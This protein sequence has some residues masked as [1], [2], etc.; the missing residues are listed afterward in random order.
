[1][2]NLEKTLWQVFYFLIIVIVIK[3][4]GN[5]FGIE[6][7]NQSKLFNYVFLGLPIVLLILHSIL[8][9]GFIR[10]I[11]FILLAST[12]GT[13][14]EHIGLKYGTF[15][16]GNY[17][18]KNQLTLFSVPV[19]VIF[20]WAVFI[21]TGYCLTNSFLYWLKKK[22]PNIK[23]KNIILLIII[24]LLDAYFITAIDLFMDPIAVYSGSWKWL[25]GGPYFGVPIGNFIG[26]FVV[27]AIVVSIFRIFEYYFPQKEKKFNK[28]IFIIPV[29]GYGAMAISYFLTAIKFNLSLAVV[30]VVFMLPQII[31]NLLLFKKFRV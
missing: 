10:G 4:I 17:I 12:T 7:E 25:E 3:V 13:F 30:G 22:K 26:W 27:T 1:M 15:F 6:F 2:K 18:Y 24:I 5:Y 16:G 31:I 21:Y 23:Q 14:F 20:F 19:S 11:F 8:T 9:L 28:S 29:L